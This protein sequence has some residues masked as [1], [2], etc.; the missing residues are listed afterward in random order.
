MV[1]FSRLNLAIRGRC[2]TGNASFQLLFCGFLIAWL[3]APAN[4]SAQTPQSTNRDGLGVEDQKLLRLLTHGRETTRLRGLEPYFVDPGFKYRRLGT[5]LEAIDVNAGRLDEDEAIDPSLARMLT[6]AG[7]TRNEQALGQ[8]DGLLGHAN[9]EL[10]T[11]V[12][13]VLGKNQARGSIQSIAKLANR[14]IYKDHYGFRRALV[15]ALQR[16]EHPDATIE[17]AKLR[18]ELD[19]QLAAD[20]DRFFANLSKEALEEA[21]KRAGQQSAELGLDRFEALAEDADVDGSSG[22][23]LASSQIKFGESTYYGIPIV[24]KRVLFVLDHSG[25]MRQYQRGMTR[26]DHAKRELIQ[27]IQSLP[28]DHEFAI[29]F[30]SVKNRWWRSELTVADEKSKEQAYRFI[31][32]IGYGDKTN[33]HAALLGAMNCAPS[34]EAV[35]VLSDG[36]PTM[37]KVIDPAAILQEVLHQNGFRGLRFHTIGIDLDPTSRRFLQQLA[38]ETGGEFRSIE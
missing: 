1:L 20:L 10:M 27:T 29:M 12:A 11:W 13:A 24:A 14:P 37:G 5:L 22:S 23:E 6:I 35:Y 32:K 25:S 16:M 18:K 2:A 17:L 9:D 15:L 8:L 26:L 21:T 36:R 33:T 31:R 34:L 4:L 7:S 38:M 3:V 30:Y 19:G 28:P